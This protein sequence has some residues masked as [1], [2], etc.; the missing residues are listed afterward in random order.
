MYCAIFLPYGQARGTLQRMTY[1]HMDA[2]NITYKCV[3]IWDDE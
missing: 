2:H 1:T 3:A